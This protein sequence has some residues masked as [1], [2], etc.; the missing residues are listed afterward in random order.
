MGGV[1]AA[2]GGGDPGRVPDRVHL[3]LASADE[4][5]LPRPAP[6]RFVTLRLPV[7]R[8]GPPL[9]R[10]YSLSGPPA[11]DRYRISVK[12]EPRRVA[13][14]YLHERVRV[15]TRCRRRAAR[16][17]SSSRRGPGPVVL[18]SAGVGV[19][20]VL[21]MLHALAGDAS[22]RPAWWLRVCAT[23]TSIRS[24]PRSTTCSARSRVLGPVSYSRRE[25]AD[26]AHV[27]DAFDAEGR[28]GMDVIP[29]SSSRWTRT[30]T[31]A[32]RRLHGRPDRRA[33]RMGGSRDRI[34]T[35][36][37]GP[38]IGWHRACRTGCPRGPG[39]PPSGG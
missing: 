7:D 23:A 25:R 32:D 33:G 13:A 30:S 35:V 16:G 20:R 12:R 38:A 8:G 17:R 9:I 24:P 36:S 11:A 5:P 18:L 28:I 31:S 3:E 14:R 15:A 34:H 29:G 39:A 1:P 37:S 6:G 26:I 21:A 27:G 10:S 2:A 19:T 4:G 22:R